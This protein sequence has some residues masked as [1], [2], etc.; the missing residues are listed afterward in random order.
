M[1]GDFV[2]G[3]RGKSERSSPVTG[4]LLHSYGMDGPFIV[5]NE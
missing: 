4:N 2:V 5:R 3:F 1:M